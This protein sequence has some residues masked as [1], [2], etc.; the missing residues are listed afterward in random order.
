MTRT[1]AQATQHLAFTRELFIRIGAHTQKL[2]A[3]PAICAG[4]TA[5][6]PPVSAKI[7]IIDLDGSEYQ[8]K[9]RVVQPIHDAGYTR[10]LKTGVWAMIGVSL[11]YA[12]RM[13]M[14]AQSDCDGGKIL[15]PRQ[16]ETLLLWYPHK[17][18]SSYRRS[19]VC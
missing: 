3:D 8:F 14:L 1:T 2:S 4:S 9:K 7:T 18:Q 15:P 17:D 11:Q 5:A 16:A 10:R 6:N 13:I 12:A 19:A